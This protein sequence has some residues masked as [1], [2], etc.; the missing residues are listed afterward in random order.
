MH[1]TG[2]S[3]LTAPGYGITLANA[4]DSLGGAVSSTGSNIDLVDS[5]A[6]GLKLGATTA[7][8]TFT[9]DSLAGAITQVASTAVSATGPISL[10]ADNGVTGTGDVRYNITL[11]SASNNFG[12]T[13]TAE[14]SA[15]TLDDAGPLTAALNGTGASTLTSAGAMNVSGTVGTSLTTTTTGTSSATTFGA[16]T[17]GTTLKVTSTGPVTETSPDVLTVAGQGTTTVSNKNV[18]VN[19]VKGAEIP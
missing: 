4:S 15:I 12:G 8:G 10:I 3:S 13:V 19:G 9:A 11:A 2:T 17:V 1:V 16:T 7:T 5:S 18:T 6:S 14:G